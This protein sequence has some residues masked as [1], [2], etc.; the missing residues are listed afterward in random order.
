MIKNDTMILPVPQVEEPPNLPP[1]ANMQIP[2]PDLLNYYKLANDRIFFIDFEIDETLMGLV[3][4]ILR[5]NRED[6]GVPAEKRKPIVFAIMSY[7]GDLDVTYTFIDVCALS[8]T[9]IITV[10][11]GS[12]MSAG[13]LLL[14]AGHK[15]YAFQHSQAMIH[16]GSGGMEGT[17]E[18]I[19]ASQNFYRDQVAK[20][21]AYILSRTNIDTKL[22]NRKKTKDWYI[23]ADEQL[24][25]GIV[26]AVINDLDEVFGG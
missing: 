18:Q 26:D 25:L 19:E 9:P 7:G 21:R 15:R 5:I 13:I 12:A 11:L 16:S 2:D 6:T 14:L 23:N 20:M 3:K 1:Q 17:F 24:D 22:F 4:E 10:N 8:K